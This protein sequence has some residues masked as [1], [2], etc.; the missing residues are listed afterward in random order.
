MESNEYSAAQTFQTSCEEYKIGEFTS[1]LQE[2][3]QTR[4]LKYSYM[5]HPLSALGILYGNKYRF[6]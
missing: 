3:M 2:L 4:T 5:I 6:S 1:L